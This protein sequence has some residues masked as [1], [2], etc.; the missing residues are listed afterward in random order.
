VTQIQPANGTDEEQWSAWPEPAHW[1]R[2]DP[3]S[4]TPGPVVV[5]AAHPDDEVLG[6][7]GLVHRLVLVGARLRFVWA[8][9]GEA[10]HPGSTSPVVATLAAA[11]RA[12]SAAALARLAAGGAPRVR[13]GLPDGGLT[14]HEADLVRRLRAVVDP[15]ELVLAPYRGDGHPDHEA[16]G[17]AAR[18]VAEHVLEYPVWTWSWAGPGDDRVPWR[19]ALRV[20]LPGEARAAKAAAVGCFRSQVEPIGPSPADGPVLP[21][22]FLAHFAR[23]FEVLLS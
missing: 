14:D 21:A 10:S 7:G 6:V 16:C 13:L 4:L 20:D 2:L 15:G 23:D 18:A 11:R 19:S 3:R 12:E 5:L 17:R 1:T 8:T 22:S 9:D